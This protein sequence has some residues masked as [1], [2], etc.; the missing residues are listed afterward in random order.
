MGEADLVRGG[1]SNGAFQLSRSLSSGRLLRACPIGTNGSQ[2][3]RSSMVID[4]E[5]IQIS[6]HLFR[7]GS[8][9]NGMQISGVDPAFGSLV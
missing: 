9:W 2:V 1:I 7:A 5:Q 6:R 8:P 3:F 4:C